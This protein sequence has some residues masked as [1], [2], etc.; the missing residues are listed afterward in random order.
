ML[1]CEMDAMDYM[2]SVEDDYLTEAFENE[3]ALEVKKEMYLDAVRNLVAVGNDLLKAFEDDD[4][5]DY[6][7]FIEEVENMDMHLECCLK[8]L[9]GTSVWDK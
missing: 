9:T 4:D 3:N 7:D 8:I 2:A 5:A 1:N 6:D